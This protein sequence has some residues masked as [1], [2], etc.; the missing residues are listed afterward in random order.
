MGLRAAIFG[1]ALG[2]LLGGSN[3]NILGP[4]GALVNIL[5]LY[6]GTYGAAIVPW[7]AFVSGLMGLAVW[8]CKLEKYCTII[9]N[10]V[11]EGFSFSVALVIGLGQ[12]RNAFGITQTVKDAIADPK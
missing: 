10:S 5:K 3:Y 2:G 11:L 12:T 1:P 6:S 7:L 8:G 4:A 9:P